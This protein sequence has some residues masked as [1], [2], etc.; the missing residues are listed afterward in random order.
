MMRISLLL[1]LLSG[2]TPEVSR[3]AYSTHGR[4]IPQ[5][6]GDKTCRRSSHDFLL[7][8]LTL[9]GEEADRPVRF[10]NAPRDVRERAHLLL[11][12]FFEDVVDGEPIPAEVRR[13]DRS[14]LNDHDRP[15]FDD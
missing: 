1:A 5:G 4:E 14:I 13:D 15:A 10:E 6:T 12:G 3:A 7:G 11:A 9:F 2:G 8:A